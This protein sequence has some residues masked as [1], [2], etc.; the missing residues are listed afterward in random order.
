MIAV[1]TP[2]LS[3]F[4]HSTAAEA[5]SKSVAARKMPPPVTEGTGFP[6]GGKPG[7]AAK[8]TAAPRFAAKQFNKAPEEGKSNLVFDKSQPVRRAPET[9]ART[10]GST[11]IESV[12]IAMEGLADPAL[13]PSPKK[14]AGPSFSPGEK[15]SYLGTVILSN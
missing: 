7:A 6:H 1:M 3:I 8:K 9:A 13:F 11:R 4:S 5:A 12:E 2:A 14:A 15:L 10:T